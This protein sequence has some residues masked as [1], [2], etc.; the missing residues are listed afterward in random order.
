MGACVF[1]CVSCAATDT[2]TL[3]LSHTLAHTHTPMGGKWLKNAISFSISMVIPDITHL[4]GF[5]SGVAIQII[6]TTYFL[7]SPGIKSIRR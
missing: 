5:L 3:T 6:L 7:P 2:S 4:Y 1:N